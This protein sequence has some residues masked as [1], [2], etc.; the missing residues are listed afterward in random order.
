MD[1][2][3]YLLQAKGCFFV[4]MLFLIPLTPKDYLCYI[5]GLGNLSDLE[6]LMVSSIGRL[7]GTVLPT[8]GGS[9]IRLHQYTK[10]SVLVA[11]AVGVVLLALAHK[12]KLERLFRTWHVK[13]AE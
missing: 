1:R 2:F 13:L 4:F 10:F 5:L 9:Y 3:D 12:E 8:L 6:L 7:F 11:V